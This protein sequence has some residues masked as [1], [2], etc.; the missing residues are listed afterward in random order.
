MVDDV[1]EVFT[2]AQIWKLL[3]D[4]NYASSNLEECTQLI[5]HNGG[6]L[7]EARSRAEMEGRTI[8]AELIRLNLL[9]D[10]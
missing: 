3:G 10:G 9:R 5:D 7:D 2:R 1:K 6:N 8:D 4:K